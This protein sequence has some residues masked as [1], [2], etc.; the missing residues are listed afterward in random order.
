MDNIELHSLA[1]LRKL[2]G[3]DRS[4]E[5]VDHYGHIEQAEV[6]KFILDGVTYKAIENPSDGYRSN[7]ESLTVSS[8][9]V[10]NKFK[11]VKVF[12]KHRKES[13]YQE[14]D[15]LEIYNMNSEIVLEIGTANIN[16]Y[17]PSFVCNFSAENLSKDDKCKLV[18]VPEEGK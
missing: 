14:D 8:E 16:D 15:I 10:K 1:G 11:P 9:R 3:L 17:Y 2:S 13:K 18:A 6:V 4:T 5:D 7:M 12:C